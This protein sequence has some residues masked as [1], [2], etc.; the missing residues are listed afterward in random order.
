MPLPILVKEIRKRVFDTDSGI[1][2]TDADL[3]N[4]SA[5]DEDEVII[6]DENK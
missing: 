3:T 1:V 6:P 2:I 4:L 5:D